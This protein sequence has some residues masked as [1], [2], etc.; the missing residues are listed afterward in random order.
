M[1]G[2]ARWLP[3]HPLVG[4]ISFEPRPTRIGPLLHGVKAISNME[5]QALFKSDPHIF[6]L[7]NA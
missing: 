3:A 1:F 6:R 5:G 2:K 7:G 4:P